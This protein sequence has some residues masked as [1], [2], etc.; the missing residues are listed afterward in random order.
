[1]SAG[2]PEVHTVGAGIGVRA[3][4]RAV[5]PASADANALPLMSETVAAT[6]PDPTGLAHVHEPAGRHARQAHPDHRL[7]DRGLAPPVTL[8]DC[9]GEPQTLEHELGMRIVASP[10][11]AVGFRS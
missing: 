11:I 4:E 3:P 2:P 10:A 1:M 7:L 9:R 8:D 5:A 6:R